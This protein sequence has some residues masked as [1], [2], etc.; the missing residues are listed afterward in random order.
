MFCC[1][2]QDDYLKEEMTG[3]MDDWIWEVRKKGE[4]QGCRQRF[5]LESGGKNEK[6][7]NLPHGIQLKREKARI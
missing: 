3:F 7:S 5:P 2:L 1:F 6:E 4:R